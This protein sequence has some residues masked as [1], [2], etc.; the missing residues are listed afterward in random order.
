MVLL[1]EEQEEELL[2]YREYTKHEVNELAI[3]AN[4]LKDLAHI[5]SMFHTYSDGRADDVNAYGSMFT[6]LEWLAEPISDFMS[7]GAPMAEKTDIDNALR[8]A[9]APDSEASGKPGIA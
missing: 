8:E 9:E 2:K 3:C 6:I 5:C 1:N 4:A 7:E